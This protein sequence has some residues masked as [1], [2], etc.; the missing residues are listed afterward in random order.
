MILSPTEEMISRVISLLKKEKTKA[1]S[2]DISR[3]RLSF[4]LLKGDGSNRKFLRVILPDSFR[5]IAIA[6]EKEEEQF[7]REASSVWTI[8]SHLRYVGVPVPAIYGFDQLTGLIIC[9]D[10]GDRQLHGYACDTDYSDPVAVAQ[11]RGLYRKTLDVLIAMQFRGAESFDTMWCWDTPVYDKG[12]MLERESGYFI[13]AFWQGI[14]QQETPTGLHAEFRALAE[15]ASM[16]SSQ[17]FLHRDFQS[18]NVMIKD[19]QIRVIDFQGGRLGPLAY[20]LA[21]LLLDPYAG[22]PI[23][24][25]DEMYEYYIQQVSGIAEIDTEQFQH[26]YLLL[27]L[28]RNLQI[29]GAFSHLSTVCG[30]VFFNKYIAPSVASLL[31]LAQAS[32]KPHL[33]VLISAV[34]YAQEKITV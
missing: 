11:L 17:F 28:Q 24:F 8:G 20:D 14:I 30:K 4:E 6:P 18:R 19:Q 27:G 32:S 16:V 26:D 25:Q 29:I 13:K 9:E 21:S 7:L 2:A 12:L 3:E 34:K 10:L 15:A 33:P 22:L 1:H 31:R 23:W 5:V